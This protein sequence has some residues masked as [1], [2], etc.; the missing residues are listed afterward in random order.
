MANIGLDLTLNFPDDSDTSQDFFNIFENDYFNTHYSK[1]NEFLPRNENAIQIEKNGHLNVNH[2]EYQKEHANIN[3]SQS[4]VASTEV[5]NLNYKEFSQ[6]ASGVD[7]N[8]TTSA[9]ADDT[10]TFNTTLVHQNPSMNCATWV[11]QNSIQCPS[12]LVA[13]ESNGYQNS[14]NRY[15]KEEIEN[16]LS[17]LFSVPKESAQ[18]CKSLSNLLNNTAIKV[19]AHSKFHENGTS[20]STYDSGIES[21]ASNS[22]KYDSN[23]ASGSLF[24]EIESFDF[25][26][27]PTSTS[28]CNIVEDTVPKHL[29]AQSDAVLS[30]P[31][32]SD[33]AVKVIDLKRDLKT[34]ESDSQKELK[35]TDAV[36]G[37]TIKEEEPNVPQSSIS[38]SSEKCEPNNSITQIKVSKIMKAPT[39]FKYRMSLP[40]EIAAN[41]AINKTAPTILSVKADP[42]PRTLKKSPEAVE[43]MIIE[44]DEDIH[45]L[46]IEDPIDPVEEKCTNSMSIKDYIMNFTEELDD[47]FT[48]ENELQNSKPQ[49]SNK[50]KVINSINLKCKKKVQA[51]YSF[52]YQKQC[53]YCSRV[54]S[55]NGHL[56]QHINQNHAGWVHQCRI[57]SKKFRTKERLS[58]HFGTHFGV[59]QKFNCDYC[60]KK[61]VYNQ[62]LNRHIASFH[63]E[64]LKVHKCPYPNCSKSFPRADH[65]IRHA[66]THGK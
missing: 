45:D 35:N 10:M 52:S 12:P 40:E 39:L 43:C 19:S 6:S 27:Y 24:D 4:S 38:K 21:L 54:F 15:D 16:I 28:D 49:I 65:M 64:E 42:L 34:T 23:N 37:A 59:G 26:Y 5:K 36:K 61:F 62:S 63:I 44:T 11:H 3:Y 13:V 29:I 57:C 58:K 1:N 2:L 51:Q 41:Q 22:P 31:S 32:T 48:C 30:S 9:F 25:D 17:D 46:I 56:L 20:A 50:M 8:L 66:N 14:Q 33:N 47:D 55:S 7:I 60:D 18:P 53:E